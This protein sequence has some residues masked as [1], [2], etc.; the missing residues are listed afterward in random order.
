ME[1]CVTLSRSHGGDTVPVHSRRV[2]FCLISFQSR[3]DY[4][5]TLLG[6]SVPFPQN[7][8]VDCSLFL[9]RRGAEG[10]GGLTCS[11]QEPWN[12]LEQKSRMCL[13]EC[14]YSGNCT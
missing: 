6:D 9:I 14:N 13:P 3:G 10:W 4:G 8:S 5:L 12:M 1:G 7:R 11:S 2:L